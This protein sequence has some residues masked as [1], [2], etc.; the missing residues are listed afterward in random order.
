MSTPNLNKAEANF[1]NAAQQLKEAARHYREA[2]E[3]QR[4]AT[5]CWYLAVAE[6][7]A[8]YGGNTPAAVKLAF[9]NFSMAVAACELLSIEVGDDEAMRS[10]FE[11]TRALEAV[12]DAAQAL[13]EALTRAGVR[14]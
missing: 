10:M 2:W 14:R 12:G 3:A 9:N 11:G 8:E 7:A 5:E 13:A 4:R 1:R 6:I